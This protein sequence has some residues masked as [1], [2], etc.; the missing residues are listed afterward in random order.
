MKPSFLLILLALFLQAAI[1]SHE[2][3]QLPGWKSLRY[4][5]AQAQQAEAYAV[6]DARRRQ[7]LLM[8]TG[9]KCIPLFM[10][11]P[12][13]PAKIVSRLFIKEAAFYQQHGIHALAIERKGLHSFQALPADKAALPSNQRCSSE[14]GGL[15]K[16][17][18]V[19]DLYQALHP[20][21]Q[22]PWFGKLL[23]MGHSEGT[24]VAMALARRLPQDKIQAVG[25]FAGA[26]PS[27][28]FDF[29]AQFREDKDNEALNSFFEDILWVSTPEQEGKFGGYP[30]ERMRSF[31]VASSPLDDA[32][33]TEMPLYVVNGL[34]DKHASPLGS[35]AF[36][37]EVLRKQPHRSVSYVTYAQL[38]HD[39]TDPNGQD[40]S[41]EVFSHFIDWAHQLKPGQVVRSYHPFL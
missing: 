6:L 7:V 3:P 13:D 18:R 32:L 24:D 29:V 21:L 36:V 39:F 27:L 26:T 22:E 30:I 10:T 23:I 15:T 11:H 40:H 28:L 38:N 33:A 20:L 34:A 17:E 16:E 37:I 2:L 9:S 31:A 41:S 5:T 25:L 14:Y 4:L 35:D 8:V 19:E 1:P 12:H